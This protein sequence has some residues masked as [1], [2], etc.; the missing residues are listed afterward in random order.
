[1]GGGRGRENKGAAASGRRK[2]PPP[3]FRLLWEEE[4]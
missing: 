1:M 4:V 2:V 3:V